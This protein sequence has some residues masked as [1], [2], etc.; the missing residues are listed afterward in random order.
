MLESIPGTTKLYLP[1]K[2]SLVPKRLGSTALERDGSED[3]FFV[4]ENAPRKVYL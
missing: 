4:G 3:E 1:Q 2:Q